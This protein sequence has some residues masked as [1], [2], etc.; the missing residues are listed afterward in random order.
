M[1]HKPQLPIGW[2]TARLD[3]KLHFCG[4]KFARA[5]LVRMKTATNIIDI[6]F[7]FI[8]L[9]GFGFGFEYG[10]CQP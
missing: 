10:Y 1:V 5:R 6:I 9:F 3:C 4:N 8:F 2:R 7:V